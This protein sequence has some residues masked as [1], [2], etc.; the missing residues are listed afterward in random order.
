MVVNDELK[1]YA[2][3]VSK[4]QL[5]ELRK[6]HGIKYAEDGRVGSAAAIAPIEEL[7]PKS[8]SKDR[9]SK[10]VKK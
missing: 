8:N 2:L 1:R 4:K 9:D 6:K 10:H 3:A 7:K 5:R